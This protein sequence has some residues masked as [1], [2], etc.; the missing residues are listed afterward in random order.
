[1]IC[2]PC[3][4]DKHAKCPGGTWCDCQHHAQHPEDKCHRCDGPNIS[5]VAPSPLW[6]AVMR[7]GSING[8][9]LFHGIVCPTCFALL[10][11]AAGIAS[12]WRLYANDVM[13]PLERVTPSG[14]TWDEA[15]WL[16]RN[17]TDRLEEDE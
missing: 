8:T 10:A 6:N 2:P 3:R 14:R 9:E 16:W 11:I 15:A 5:W 17:P 12:G 7:G 4:K 1:M 13:V